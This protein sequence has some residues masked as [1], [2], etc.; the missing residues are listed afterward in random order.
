MQDDEDRRLVEMQGRIE[1]LSR[2]NRQRMES[3]KD[4]DVR[5]KRVSGALSL[6][7]QW[8]VLMLPLLVR[9]GSC[10]QARPLRASTPVLM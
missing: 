2:S 5:I 6:C 7:N 1:A 8:G 10:S 4:R 3:A 9:Y